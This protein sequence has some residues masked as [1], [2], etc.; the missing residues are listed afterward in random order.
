[1]KMRNDITAEFARSVLNYDPESGL[2]TKK[3][4]HDMSTAWNSRCANKACGVRM[5]HGYISIRINN[6]PYLAHRLAWLVT[7][8]EWPAQLID[9]INGDRSDNRLCN[10]REATHTQNRFNAGK[11]GHNKSG[12]KGV[13][14]HPFSG[15]WRARVSV[16]RKDV[17][18]GYFHTKEEAHAVYQRRVAEFHSEFTRK[19]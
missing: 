14:F 12:F 18:L 5:A 7:H 9:H 1:M 19:G 15:L 6:R 2:F 17:C 8:G 10:L 4:R 16:N 3:P 11:W 13:S